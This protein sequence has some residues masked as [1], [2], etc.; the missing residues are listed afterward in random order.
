VKSVTVAHRGRCRGGPKRE[1]LHGARHALVGEVQ[2]A[3]CLRGE[4]GDRVEHAARKDQAAVEGLFVGVQDG[5]PGAERANS[6]LKDTASNNITRGWI[7]LMGLT[8][9]TLWLACAL[10]IRNQRI[11][12][13]WDARQEDNARR[14]AAGL[15]PKTRRRRRVS[16]AALTAGPPWQR[17]PPPALQQPSR[18]PD[19][20]RPGP[21]LPE[22]GANGNSAA[23]QP[24]PR[25]LNPQRTRMSDPNVNMHPVEV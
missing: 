8:P 10:A 7:R 14:A 21:A 23:H 12:A 13:A 1:V 5:A 18:S 19:N 17:L 9:L 11:L 2:T 3:A 22:S 6:T 20:S 16:L 25:L 15:P 4:I 24:R